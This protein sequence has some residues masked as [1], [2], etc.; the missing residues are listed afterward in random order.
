MGLRGSAAAAL[1]CRT[2]GIGIAYVRTERVKVRA[3]KRG[4]RILTENN[5]QV[6]DRRLWIG[7]P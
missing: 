1:D 6:S 2:D 5:H 3:K 7:N 4:T